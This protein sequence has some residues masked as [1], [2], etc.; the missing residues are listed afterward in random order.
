MEKI[1]WY[2]FRNNGSSISNVFEIH[3]MLNLF[4]KAVKGNGERNTESSSKNVFLIQS[5]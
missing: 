4:S 3:K 1:E 5:I 2:I